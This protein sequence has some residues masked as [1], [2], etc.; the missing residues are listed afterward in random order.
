MHDSFITSN[1]CAQL[2]TVVLFNL[3]RSTY[4]FL[5]IFIRMEITERTVMIVDNGDETFAKGL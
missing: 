3:T 2:Q 5:S 1:I 4:V